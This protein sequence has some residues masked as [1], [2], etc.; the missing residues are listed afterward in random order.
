MDVFLQAV[1]RA[2][3]YGSV[4]IAVILPVR[5]F[6]KRAP[7]KYLCLLWLLAGLRLL[8]PFEMESSLSLQPDLTNTGRIL[9]ASQ[10]SPAPA[11]APSVSQS[12]D[13]P[14]STLS[15][16]QAEADQDPNTSQENRA[17]NYPLILGWIWAAVSAGMLLYSIV[18]Y[19]RLRWRVRDSVILSEGVWICGKLDSSFVLGFFRPQIYLN[20]NL[21]STERAF[22]L[23]HERCHIRRRD[24]WWKLLGFFTLAIHWFNP[25]VWLA[26]SLLCRDLEMA[27][28]EAVVHSMEADARKAYSAALLSCSNKHRSIAACPVAFGEIS[29][30]ARIKNVLNYKKPSLWILICV[31]VIV[32]ILIVCFFTAPKS[33]AASEQMSDE[34]LLSAFYSAMEQL[35]TGS[36]HFTLSMESVDDFDY[37]IGQTQEFWVENGNWYHTIALTT[38]EGHITDCYAS[39]DGIQYACEYSDDIP[40][41]VN[42]DWAQLPESS[43][44]SLPILSKDWRNMEVLEISRSSSDGQ[45][46]CTVTLQDDLDVGGIKETYYENIW[47]IQIDGNGNIID[48]LHFTHGRL[49][50]KYYSFNTGQHEGYYDAKVYTTV[51]F[52]EPD[53]ETL[54]QLLANVSTQ[55]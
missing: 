6:F 42:R 7:K 40:N 22:V 45:D 21:S 44:T 14:I 4:M 12:T 37:V 50:F 13:V 34:D 35:Q 54:H 19:L 30:K 24:H 31:V 3:L 25:L 47:E 9:Y 17:V 36:S 18:S 15:S 39:I 10:A 1:L 11:T 53:S 2:S 32:S 41:F 55:P 46:I 8:L 5:L 26:Y 23:T 52:L 43:H 29:V 20:A 16:P 27:C 51:S 28:D 49:L 38:T 33:P 48:M